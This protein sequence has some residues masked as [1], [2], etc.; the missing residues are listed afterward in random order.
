MTFF[1]YHPLQK[2]E[3]QVLQA[4]LYFVTEFNKYVL[5][6][7]SVP[8]SMLDGLKKKKKS[9]IIRKIQLVHQGACNNPSE[10]RVTSTI[11]L[12]FKQKENKNVNSWKFLNWVFPFVY[13]NQ[14]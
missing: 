7:C 1:E 14:Y 12:P 2:S 9:K 10:E 6:T 5:K 13:L 4:V 3:I 8:W 11:W